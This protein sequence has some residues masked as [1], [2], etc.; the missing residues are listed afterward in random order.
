MF[1]TIF[2]TRVALVAREIEPEEEWL[3]KLG[4][5]GLAA[6]GATSCARRWTIRIFE[7]VAVN[8]VTDA[9]TLAH[10]LK[11]DSVLGNL[12]HNVTHTDDSIAVDGKTFKVFKTKDPGGNRLV[13]AWA[14]ISW[15]SPPD[16]F[17]K[18]ADAEEA[19]ARLGE[20]GDYFG[21]GDGS[22]RYFCVGRER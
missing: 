18:G 11:Y 15:W 17:T 9:K 3:S 19:H 22:G 6:S 4:S 10:L 20:K 1:L 7:F 21:A 16:L 14:R 5:T 12:H 13:L 8:D 2:L